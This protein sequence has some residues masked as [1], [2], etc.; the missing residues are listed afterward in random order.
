MGCLVNV[1][2]LER[3]G[4]ISIKGIALMATIFA[5]DFGFD[6]KF[7]FGNLNGDR[8]FIG[9][10]GAVVSSKSR[11]VGTSLDG[12]LDVA[13]GRC[14]G[15]CRRRQNAHQHND[16]QQQRDSFLHLDYPLM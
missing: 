15:G 11:R 3:F 7:V 13:A 5:F 1:A 12:D 9:F 2:N 14:A 8:V 6:W 10:L 16:N 4:A